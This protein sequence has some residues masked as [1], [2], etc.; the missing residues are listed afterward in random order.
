MSMYLKM[1]IKQLERLKIINDLTT[2]FVQSL[3]I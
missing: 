1:G 3:Y 2:G